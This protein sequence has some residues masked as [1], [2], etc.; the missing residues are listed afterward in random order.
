MKPPFRSKQP[1]S[2]E[3]LTRNRMAYSILGGVSGSAFSRH[4]L[5]RYESADAIAGTRLPVLWPSRFGRHGPRRAAAA[6]RDPESVHRGLDDVRR[7]PGVI[8]PVILTVAGVRVPVLAA[9]RT[10]LGAHRRGSR[11][12]SSAGRDCYCKLS[13]RTEFPRARKQGAEIKPQVRG[14]NRPLAATDSESAREMASECPIS[15]AFG[16]SFRYQI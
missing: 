6:A 1:D 4:N 13:P 7:R 5:S 16:F 3:P 8:V 14:S 10:R 15:Q 11:A 9:S 2:S 12:G